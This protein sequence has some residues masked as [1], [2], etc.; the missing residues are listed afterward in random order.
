[1]IAHTLEKLG[2]FGKNRLF[3]EIAAPSSIPKIVLVLVLAPVPARQDT[4]RKHPRAT[5]HPNN[6]S[7][8][9]IILP[10]FG[11]LSRWKR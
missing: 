5:A 10:L 9:R 6:P 3:R 2:S 8:T 11:S 4:V 1:M 7:V